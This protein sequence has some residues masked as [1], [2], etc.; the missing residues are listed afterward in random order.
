MTSVGANPAREAIPCIARQPI[1]T[2]DESVIGYELFFR[3][4]PEQRSFKSDR[5][6]A[7]SATIDMLNVVG[8]GMLCDG[9][10]AFINCTRHLLLSDYFSL[11]PP[12]DVVIE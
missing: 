2:A 4:S 5:D 10:L 12:N 11:L 3:Q 6:E 9:R 8:L 1:L 7:T